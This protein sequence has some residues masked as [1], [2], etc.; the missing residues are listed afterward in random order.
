MQVDGHARVHHQRACGGVAREDPPLHAPVHLDSV[1]AFLLHPQDAC[2]L[3]RGTWHWGPFPLGD[4]PVRFCNVQGK[5]YRE[6]N[7]CVELDPVL[8]ITFEITR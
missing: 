4:T 7:A 3:H 2:V 8:D 5:R 6:D 1:R